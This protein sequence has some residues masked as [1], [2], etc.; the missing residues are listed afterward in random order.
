MT[1]PDGSTVT[2][3]GLSSIT[4]T[5]S[6][7]GTYKVHL[8]VTDNEEMTAA[9]DL[10]AFDVRPW[11]PEPGACPSPQASFCSGD[12]TGQSCCSVCA[13]TGNAMCSAVDPVSTRGLPLANNIHVSSQTKLPGRSTLMGNAAF[14][15]GMAVVQ[16]NAPGTSTGHWWLID[17]DG[18]EL[19]YG[20]TS[21]SPTPPSGAFAVLTQTI[22]GYHLANAGP[23]EAIKVAGNYSYDFDLAGKLI[24]VTDPSNNVQ[25]LAYDTSDE[26]PLRH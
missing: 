15:Y 1:Q 8:V 16:A 3:A 24:Q 4:F 13:A 20:V 6:M 10:P 25:Q 26:P 23:P 2:G 22:T 17:G 7:P 11:V 21:S 12:E 9:I 5:V 14:T 18:Q 19:D